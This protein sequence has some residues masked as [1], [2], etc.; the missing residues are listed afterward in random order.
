VELRAEEPGGS[1]EQGVRNLILIATG[2]LLATIRTCVKESDTQDLLARAV[3]TLVGNHQT[4]MH[5]LLLIPQNRASIAVKLPAAG[6]WKLEL[7]VQDCL[8]RALA[9]CP[10]GS[11][12]RN[13]LVAAQ[14]VLS[15]KAPISEERG[16]GNESS[17]HESFLPVEN[18][19]GDNA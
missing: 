14:N 17:L 11:S 13:S 5:P 16:T 3:A 4:W 8:T 6:K 15:A 18:S 2:A 1:D 7:T 12:A 9:A 10:E 19:T